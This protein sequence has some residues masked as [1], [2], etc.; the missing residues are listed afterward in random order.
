MLAVCFID[1]SVK[2]IEQH[3]EMVRIQNLIRALK[4]GVAN[5]DASQIRKMDV[6]ELGS[7][8]GLVGIASCLLG[9]ERVIMTDLPYTMEL[10]KANVERN[11][12]SRAVECRVCDWLQPP[13]FDSSWR[14]NVLLIADCVWIEDLIKPLLTTIS[15][16]I[17]TTH[18]E[19]CVI[20]SYQRRGK[21]THDLFW[22]GMN[23]VFGEVEKLEL[24]I[25]KP[26]SLNIYQCK[27][28]CQG[29]QIAVM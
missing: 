17:K 20:V 5:G 16:F 28:N 6:L 27:I 23:E 13:E 8:C 25:N 21:S 4:L 9:A 2:Y 7:G 12:L 29:R 10:M 14:S 19:V 11:Q 18:G 26:E 24:N 1:N 22:A 15:S 3:P